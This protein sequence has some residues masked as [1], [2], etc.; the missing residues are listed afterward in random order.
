MEIKILKDD[1]RYH[2]YVG[3]KNLWLS[4]MELIELRRTINSLPL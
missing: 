1:D 2:V 4:R 3:D